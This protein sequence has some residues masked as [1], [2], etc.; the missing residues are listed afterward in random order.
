MTPY[1]MVAVLAA[2]VGAGAANAVVGNGTLITFP[3]LLAV[4]L[5][6]VTAVVSNAL[7]LVPGSV[8]A[9]VG[10]RAALAGQRR[11]V[12]RLC[13][14]ALF[15]GICGA[16]LLLVLPAAA[17]ERIVPVLVGLAL[18]L[19]ACQPLIARRAAR[20]RAAAGG[21][22]PRGEG[23]P[24]LAGL[25]LASVYGGY[26]SASQGILYLALMNAFLDEPLHRLNAIKNV[27]VAVVNSVAAL[28]FLFVARFDWTAVLL[29][30]VGSTVGGQV[31]ARLAGFLR[32]AVLR[33]LIV[34]VGAL[35]LAELL[36]H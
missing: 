7:G 34:A 15:G 33:A 12:L 26:F 35:G 27:L 11:R 8:S 22:G 29:I 3:V 20:R 31:G 23:P 17:V 9:A 10:Y 16:V 18:V 13:V 6:P 1:E 30:A 32:P 19:V 25:T 36:R 14:G 28:V 2:G 24:L 4:G 5:P 21:P